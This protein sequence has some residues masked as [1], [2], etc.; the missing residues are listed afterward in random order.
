MGNR[1]AETLFD[2]EAGQDRALGLV[3]EHLQR[4]LEEGKLPLVSLDLDDT[5][6][7]FGPNH[8]RA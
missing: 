4:I 1:Q 5:F 2:G 6:L 7:P 8:Q 3:T